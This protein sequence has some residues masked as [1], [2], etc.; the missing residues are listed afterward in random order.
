MQALEMLLA[1][2]DMTTL[3]LIVT[4][5]FFAT[6]YL[7]YWGVRK[8]VERMEEETPIETTSW[9]APKASEFWK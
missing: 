1:S 9:M 2:F 8:L 3:F 6:V 4:L 7:M 5:W